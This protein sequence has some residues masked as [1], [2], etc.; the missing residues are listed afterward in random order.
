MNRNLIQ[1]FNQWPQGTVALT[2]WFDRAGIKPN[3]LSSYK[4][5]G[6]IESIGS[7]AYKKA[8]DPVQWMGALFAVQRQ[9]NYNV[10]VG[11]LSA[12]ELHGSGHYL[13]VNG[14]SISI[15]TN[16]RVKNALPDWFQYFS[17]D[18]F[19]F[20]TIQSNL[21][22]NALSDLTDYQPA[23]SAYTVKISS[24][25][26]ALLEMVSLVPQHIDADQAFKVFEHVSGIDPKKMS[27]LLQ[28][29]TSVKTKRLFMVMAKLTNNSWVK[30][31]NTTGV[32]FGSGQRQLVK[33]GVLDKEYRITVPKEWYDDGYPEY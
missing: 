21:F 31:L 26:Q 1:I 15:L 10:H 32:D 13:P 17:K 28:A 27:A 5:T 16:D 6:W 9:L 19:Y 22:A 18:K 4:R 20:H 14:N 30:D 24:K 7:G 3:S 12:L 29:C 8:G 11:A 25:E 2:R 23:M 33:G